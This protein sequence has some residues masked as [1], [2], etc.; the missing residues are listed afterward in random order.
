MEST[1]KKSD[2]ANATEEIVSD[3]TVVKEEVKLEQTVVTEEIKSDKAN[4]TGRRKRAVARVR[5]TPGTGHRMVNGRKFK[6]YFEKNS[7]ILL[8][9]APVKLLG[10]GNKINIIA[11]VFGGGISGQAGAVRLGIAR[12]LVKLFPE[13]KTEIKKMGFLTRD[14]RVVERKKYGRPKARKRFQFSKR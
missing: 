9:E 11:N 5:I 14:A 4:A 6:N 12:A 1:E 2:K 3:G 7:I 13:R 10:L 8:T